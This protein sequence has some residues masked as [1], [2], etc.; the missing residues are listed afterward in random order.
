MAFAEAILTRSEGLA[1]KRLQILFNQQIA[2]QRPLVDE[3][4]GGNATCFWGRP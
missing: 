2:A 1:Q 3:F 4:A